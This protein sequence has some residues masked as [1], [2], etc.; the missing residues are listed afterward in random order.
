MRIDRAGRVAI[1]LGRDTR[2]VGVRRCYHYY[3]RYF[4]DI[5]TPLQEDKKDDEDEEVAR[6]S[7][8]MS[9]R[10]LDVRWELHSGMICTC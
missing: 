6:K 3:Q 10:D 2:T 5:A 9:H 1:Q 7:H 4:K 8:Q